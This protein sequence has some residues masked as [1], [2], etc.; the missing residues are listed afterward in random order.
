MPA[1]TSVTAVDSFV[2]GSHNFHAGQAGELPESIAADL[3]SAGLVT[4]GGEQ[5]QGA[6]PSETKPA[7]VPARK[8]GTAPA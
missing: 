6:G 5:R 7:T 1:T 8:R 2:H 4:L 3:A